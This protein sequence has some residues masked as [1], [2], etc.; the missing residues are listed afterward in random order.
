MKMDVRVARRTKY[1]LEVQQSVQS[2]MQMYRNSGLFRVG[3]IM[4]AA[5]RNK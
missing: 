5:Q 3:N 4:F 1:D 2:R